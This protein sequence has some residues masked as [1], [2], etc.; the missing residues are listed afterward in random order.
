MVACA[1]SSSSE[2]PTADA[3]PSAVVARRGRAAVIVIAA[4]AVF[5]AWAAWQM[6]FLCDDAFITFRY[7][8]NAVDGH[9][10]VW[11]APPFQPVEG[12][13]GFLW[14]VLLWATWS[15]FGVEPP[16]AANVLSLLLG[17]ASF[18]VCAMAA[19]RL[20][21]RD[22]R[23]TRPI[24]AVAVLAVLATNRTYLQW[25][26]GGLETALFNLGFVGWVLWAFRGAPHGPRWLAVWAG[27][28]AV[29]ALTRPDGL[30]LVA[31]TAAI[32]ICLAVARRLTWRQ[33]ALG[34][35]PLLVVAAHMLWRRAVYGDW[36]PNTY[37]A[38]VTAPWPEAGW[39]YLYCFAFEHGIWTWPLVAAAAAV[40]EFARRRTAAPLLVLARLPAAA[41]VAA[42]LFQV[43][44]Y[45]V[46]VGADHFEY[47]VLSHIV[48]LG[49]LATA[50]LAVRMRR[51]ALLPVAVSSFTALASSVAW[52]H[53]WRP[54]PVLYPEYSALSDTVP[55]WARP[56]TREYDRHQAWLQL[57]FCFRTG[58]LARWVDRQRE[59]W[60]ERTR[61][62]TDPHDIPVVQTIAAG[63]VAWVL[64]DVAVLDELGLNDWVV[65]RVPTTERY[66]PFLP[67]PLLE[68]AI[69]RADTD[70]DGVYTRAELEASFAAVAGAPPA[71]MRSFVDRLLL[72]FAEGA[73]QALSRAEVADLRHFFR[74][75][76]FIAHERRAPADYVAALDP[77]V[78]VVDRRVVVRPR[79][80]P[81][82]PQRLREI[83]R[84][85]RERLR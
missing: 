33:A 8:S 81:L 3:P 80:V 71:A 24:V 62:E 64:P 59:L 26:T 1:S 21:E 6:R 27:A 12:Y 73:A 22:G 57:Q 78:T 76:R 65:A 85:W 60:P 2:P 77:N 40:V 84:A 74:T 51:G 83:E 69:E 58:A 34:L 23:L 75:M 52:L 42:T 31:A 47:R 46:R 18:G 20:R 55:A 17:L 29:T 5:V 19:L 68:Q 37:Y 14:A 67:R 25:M 54:E 7:V 61:R 9:G 38:K 41:A 50:A 72:L 30:L 13:T 66:L 16:D 28:A 45:L 44:F 70:G 36:L 11:N 43:G 35:A 48:P 49:T 39:R 10:L 63:Y 53:S 15:W 4:L 32:G 82:T 79:E 56:L